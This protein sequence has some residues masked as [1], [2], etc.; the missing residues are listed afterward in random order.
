MVDAADARIGFPG[1]R[2][3]GSP[4]AHMWFYHLGPQWT[5]RMLLT[6]DCLTGRDAAKLGLVLQAPP[7]EELEDVVSSLT[8]RMGLIDTDL[9]SANKR[10]VNIAMELC[11]ARTIAKLAAEMDARA[12]LSTGDRKSQFKEDALERGLKAAFTSRDAPFGD[13][14]AKVGW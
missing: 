3:N 8:Q 13:G 1:V 11:G 6:G 9:L 14:L 7:I 5:K 10:I 2:A 12:H 4:P